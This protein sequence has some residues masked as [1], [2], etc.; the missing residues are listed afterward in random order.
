MA[1]SLNSSSNTAPTW[2]LPKNLEILPFMSQFKNVNLLKW[3]FQAQSSFHLFKNL[4]TANTA[5]VLIEH[6]AD[7]NFR[8][9]YGDS[10]LNLA[11]SYGI[12]ILFLNRN[13]LYSSYAFGSRMEVDSPASL[14]S[15]VLNSFK[16]LKNVCVRSKRTYVFFFALNFEKELCFWFCLR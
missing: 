7:I 3:W 11:A 12:E 10:P 2:M 8:N 1:I 6:G 5:R 4:G 14:V 13:K 15:S 9:D 16:A